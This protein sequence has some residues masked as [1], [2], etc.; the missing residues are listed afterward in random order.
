MNGSGRASAQAYLAAIVESSDDDAI[1]SKDLNGIIQSCNAAGERL[2]GYTRAELIGKPVRIL[3]PAERQGEEDDILARIGRG[4]RVD[5]FETIRL[6]KDQRRINVSLTVSP[7]RDAA[8]RIIGASKIARDIT[9]QKRARAAEAYLA[10]IV[11]SSDDAIISKNLDGIIQSCNARAEQLFGYTGSELVGHSIRMVIP[12]ERQAEEDEILARIGRGERIDHFETVRLRKDGRP[13]DISLSVSPIRGSDG[14]IIGVAKIAHDITERKRL[15]R[16]LEAQREWFRVTL[17]SIGD[18]VIASDPDGRVTYMNEPAETV[19]GWLASKAIGQPLAEVFRIIN[20]K[21]RKPV[22]N[23][24]D[25][26]LRTGHVVGLA[27]HT[28]LIDRNGRERPIADSAAPIRAAE[29]G[30][31]GVVLVFRDVTEQRRAEDAIAEQRE[32]FETTL[33]SIGD[34][35]IATDVQGHVVFMN[36][37]AEHLTGWRLAEARGRSCAAVFNIINENSRRAVESPVMRVLAEGTVV[38][39][40]NHTVLIAADG[41]ER[42]IDDSGAPIRS[43]DGRVVGVVLVFRDVSERR[44]GELERRDAALERERLLEAERAARGDAERASRVKDEFVAMVSHELRTPLNAIL[45]WTQL[46]VVPAASADVIARGLDVISRNTRLQAQLISDLLDISRIV[47]GKLRLDIEEVDL[48]SVLGDAIDTVQQDADEKR[49]VI[50]RD[51][52]T[53]VGTIAG[54]AARVQQIVWNLLS[55]AIKF[56]P[57]SGQISVRLRKAGLD[58]KITITDTGVGIHPD[59]LPHIFDRFRQADQS[60]TRRFGGLGL[61]LSIVKHLVELHGGSI[62]A[63]S[64]GT[65]RGTVFTIILPSSAGA[66][67]ALPSPSGAITRDAGQPRDSL[68]DFRILVVEDEPDTCEFL[69]RFLRSY[70]ADVIVAR[71]AEEALSRLSGENVDIVVSDIGLP[72]VDGYDLMRRIRQR[73]ANA[74][75]ATPAVAL[76]AYARTEDRM[77]ALRAGYQAHLAKPIEPAELVATIASFAGLIEA[78]RRA[79]EAQT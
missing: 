59:F 33:E 9:D 35:V 55:N 41:T 27:N 45:G 34:A 60:I 70:G 65:G 25:L 13:I 66:P 54:D 14:R 49:I 56:T 62:V 15:A 37:V 77:R 67:A 6:T 38:G 8:G 44:R 29:G 20:E 1:L 52:N 73:P 10:A 58:A 74:G 16:E 3:I 43:R 22:E 79:R 75:G 12:P 5:H 69:D 63:E 51:L 11:E 30:I 26:V 4:E 7:V 39:L 50:N 36:P 42:P 17:G 47:T 72:D 78:G 61:G 23:P 19:T 24:A 71:S 21:T 46:M 40:A 76:T 57:E 18:A 31:L 2:F 28:V 53:N 32:W 64:A 68:N 48:A